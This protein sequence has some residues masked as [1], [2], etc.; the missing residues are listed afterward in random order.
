MRIV[1]RDRSCIDYI[2]VPFELLESNP[3]V[4]PRLSGI[5][6]VLHSASM[7]LAGNMPGCVKTAERISSWASR[8]DSP[9]VGEHLA[10]TTASSSIGEGDQADTIQLGFTVAPPMNMESVESLCERVVSLRRTIN[11]PLALENSPLYF[12]VPGSS[13]TQVDY[14]N[15]IMSR[16]DA[17]LLLDITHL[18]VT[19][20]NFGLDVKSTLEKLPMDRVLEIHV[21]GLEN[22][23]GIFWDNH[24]S[25]IPHEVLDLLRRSLSLSSPRAITLE[26]NWIGE[27]S[28]DSIRH[29]ICKVRDIVDRGAAC[30]TT[31]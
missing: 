8:I 18:F 10:F 15:A 5:P 27:F 30:R 17:H 28:D 23:A 13:M 9:W 20:A 7:S 25:P 11:R 29:Q 4:Y 16:V 3:L 22:A 2:E 21:S 19:C 6:A 14:I 12:E 24:A 31:P 1:E 26:Y